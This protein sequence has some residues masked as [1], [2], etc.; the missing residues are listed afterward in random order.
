[1]KKYI[2]RLSDEERKELEALVN[3]GKA[4][5]HKIKHANI[6]LAVDADGP[7][8]TDEEAATA[9]RRGNIIN[10]ASATEKLT[11]HC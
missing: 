7:A 9:F 4:A 8:W 11:Q 5:A 6:L 1:M 2:V 3:T 10:H